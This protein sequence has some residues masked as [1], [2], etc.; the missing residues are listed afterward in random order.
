MSLEFA[1]S[2][3]S[4]V[5]LGRSLDPW[6]GDVLPEL[7]PVADFCEANNGRL[8][9]TFEV[10][11]GVSSVAVACALEGDRSVDYVITRGANGVHRAFRVVEPGFRFDVRSS[12]VKL[13]FD[14]KTKRL[15]ADLKDLKVSIN[16]SGRF[17]E[18][19]P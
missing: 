18:V 10:S 14:E 1:R 17:L 4:A 2:Y 3:G 13:D 9:F 5:S 12:N 16:P 15:L 8:L 6:F 7:K 11:D 19:V